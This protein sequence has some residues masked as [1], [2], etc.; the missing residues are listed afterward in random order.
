MKS[1]SRVNFSNIIA[2]YKQLGKGNVRLTQSTLFLTKDITGT[3]TSYN[4]DVLENQN[5]QSPEEIRL[6]IN[7]EFIATELGVYL[8]GKVSHD[9]NPVTRNILLTNTLRQLSS[10]QAN[11]VSPVYDGKLKIA[12]N[13]V[14]FME[15]WD[16][17]KHEII[18]FDQFSYDNQGAN[19]AGNKVDG[20]RYE[21][22]GMYELAPM[23]TLSGAKK[24]EITIEMPSAPAVGTFA[25]VDMAQNASTIRIE[26]ICVM[27]RGLNAQNAARFQ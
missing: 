17:K 15:K 12:V 27:L 21:N 3:Q 5:N 2:K 19:N 22:D 10:P 24:N 4:F 13:N 6:N 14:I 18:P 11:L 20:S 23:I 9:G 1:I 26:K 7:D 8:Y 25:W 16:T